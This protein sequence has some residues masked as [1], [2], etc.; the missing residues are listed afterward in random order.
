MNAGFDERISAFL[1]DEAQRL[2]RRA[3]TLEESVAS[4][5]PRLVRR[6]GGQ[7]RAL[8]LLLAAV[9]LLA[10]AVGMTIAV[11]SGLVRLPT[12][13][14]VPP[15]TVA[16]EYEAVVLRL[17]VNGDQ[18]EVVAIGVARD[19]RE[20]E[21]A[22][23]PGGWVAYPIGSGFLAPMGAVSTGGLLA[24]PSGPARSMAWTIHDLRRPGGQ[25]IVVS[26]TEQDVEQLQLTPYFTD[27]MRPSVFWGSDER[28][29][30][31]WYERLADSLDW[32]LTIVAGRTGEA[33]SIDVPDGFLVAPRWAADGSGVLLRRGFGAPPEAV[34]HLD[35]SVTDLE[36]GEESD[37]ACRTRS[38]SGEAVS[39]TAAG[40]VQAGPGGERRTLADAANVTY[41]CLSPDDRSAAFDIGIGDGS[42]DV[43]A[44]SPVTGL[45]AP[46]TDGWIEI[47]GSF[48]GWMEVVP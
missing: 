23:L 26:G 5:A 18:H 44:S 31:S 25:P 33:I 2:A 8:T 36:A 11:G 43:T 38:A 14:E 12:I 21:I 40:V 48:A 9:L 32:H 30:I 35:G 4:V 13:V 15:S 37:P 10:A 24:I 45:I 29:A 1:A 41:A 47:E 3:P 7:S 42:G 16:P 46:G 39:V 22:R 28:V 20:R 34:L 17:A 6:A 27:Q 19:G